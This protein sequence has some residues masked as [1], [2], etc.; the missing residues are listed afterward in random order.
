[1]N[2]HMI[3]KDKQNE[4]IMFFRHNYPYA[5]FMQ[6][7]KGITDRKLEKA[8]GRDCE[9]TFG[10]FN[11]IDYTPFL[12]LG[13]GFMRVHYYALQ[14]TYLLR[15]LF[16]MNQ[17]HPNRKCNRKK[18]RRRKKNARQ[19]ILCVSSDHCRTPRGQSSHPQQISVNSSGQPKTQ[20]NLRLPSLIAMGPRKSLLDSDAIL[21]RS[22]REG[23][24]FLNQTFTQRR[25][26]QPQMGRD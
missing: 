17:T 23:G 12:K 26:R 24:N 13:G 3:F 22:K 7:S 6:I 5:K 20:A 11:S 16:C 21:R 2:H 8:G 19:E 10:Y 18:K 1:M 4:K 9:G 14:L 25:L 15:R